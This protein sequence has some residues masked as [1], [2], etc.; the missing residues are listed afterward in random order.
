M[1][2]DYT[3]SDRP[4]PKPNLDFGAT[5]RHAGGRMTSLLVVH[6]QMRSS[7]A[8]PVCVLS[9]SAGGCVSTISIKLPGLA[10][11]SLEDVIVRFS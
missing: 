8:L 1:L 10:G 5:F 4:D 6:G 2:A 11:S 9:G 7:E 3:T